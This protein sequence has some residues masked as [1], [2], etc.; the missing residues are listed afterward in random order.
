MSSA[1]FKI[2]TV[3]GWLFTLGGLSNAQQPEELSITQAHQTQYKL[4]GSVGS[5][6]IV[7]HTVRFEPKVTQLSL[8]GEIGF[9]K[10]CAG[11]QEWHHRL[12]F[13]DVGAILHYSGFGDRDVF[14]QAVGL[15]PFVNFK[16]KLISSV[17]LNLRLGFGLAYL[18]TTYDPFENLTNNVI[19]SHWNNL[20]QIQIGVSYQV[21]PQLKMELSSGLTHYSNGKVVS[22]N[23]GINAIQVSLGLTY[24][25]SGPEQRYQRDTSTASASL[26]K[27]RWFFRS[28]FGVHNSG[29]GT[30]PHSVFT[31]TL[32]Y[33]R[34][35]SPVNNMWFG[36]TYAFDRSKLQL[37]AFTEKYGPRPPGHYASDVSL[38]V[39]DEVM[40][41]NVGIW[42]ICG[43]YLYN[44]EYR[45]KPIYLKLGVQYYFLD[46]KYDHRLFTF[47]NIKSHLGVADYFEIGL[48]YKL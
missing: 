28:G 26:R 42:L 16:Q 41:G 4:L 45:I 34:A 1:G 6:V 46:M 39:G 18:D 23:L 29:L 32:T 24:S 13:P 36:T 33:V 8:F 44:P 10:L 48:G 35:T 15:F 30:P 9:A 47:V 25:L 31:Q 7:P 3:I 11:D 37:L 14:G 19:G 27:N 12:G 38:F 5:G 21:Q 40:V 20:T 17:V 2:F 43:A 22:P